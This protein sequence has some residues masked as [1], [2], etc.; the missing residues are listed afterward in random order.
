MTF[1]PQTSKLQIHRSESFQF[2]LLCPESKCN[3]SS[4]EETADTT[5]MVKPVVHEKDQMLKKAEEKVA[6]LKVGPANDQ[7]NAN[8]GSLLRYSWVFVSR[9]TNDLG[10]FHWPPYFFMAKH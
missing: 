2:G 3:T 10:A 1:F 5:G 7:N 8:P 4:V 6:V 9:K